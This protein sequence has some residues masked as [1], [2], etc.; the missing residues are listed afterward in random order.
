MG[1]SRQKRCP[2]SP[3]RFCISTSSSSHCAAVKGQE[4]QQVQT[5]VRLLEIVQTFGGLQAQALLN[6]PDTFANI[7]KK[8]GDEIVVFND[9]TKISELLTK[10]IPQG[11]INIANN[12]GR[13]Q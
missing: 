7:K 3:M 1:P 11:D 2:T 8:L 9:A 6:A 10:L 5:A 13:T 12:P 4:W